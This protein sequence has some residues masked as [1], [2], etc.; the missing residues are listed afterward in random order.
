[1]EVLTHVWERVDMVYASRGNDCLRT[2][3]RELKKLRRLHRTGG[4]E[5]LFCGLD[6]LV[7]IR[8]VCNQAIVVATRANSRNGAVGPYVKIGFG[9]R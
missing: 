8:V 4:E 3:A 7:T 9:N 2:N 6:E 1:L 5:D